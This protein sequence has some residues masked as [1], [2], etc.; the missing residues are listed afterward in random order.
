M[1]KIIQ[2]KLSQKSCIT[3][4]APINAAFEILPAG[5]VDN[6]LK[7]ENKAALQGV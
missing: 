5:S 1:K 2:K 3:V 7:A 6:Q 4:F